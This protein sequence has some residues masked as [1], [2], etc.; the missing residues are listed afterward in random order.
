MTEAE[1]AACRNPDEMLAFLR[2]GGHLSS[3]KD[4]LFAVACC[5]RVWPLLTDERS[6]RAVEAAEG[7]A[8][9]LVTAAQL[10]EVRVAAHDAFFHAKDVEYRAEA[11]VNFCDSV[12]YSRVCVTLYA[13]AAARVAVSPQASRPID[14]LA[15]YQRNESRWR[16]RRDRARGCHY[17]LMAAAGRAE[18]ARQYQA[19]GMADDAH[20]PRDVVG[21]ASDAEDAVERLEA[22]AQAALLRDLFGPLPFRTA[23]LAASVLAWNNR[24]VVRLAAAIYEEGH[25]AD[26]PLLADALLDA[27]CEDDE[28]VAHLRAPGPHARGCHGLDLVLG[29]R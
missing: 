12:A 15:A 14:L 4:R 23:A 5:R 10:R 26:L 20:P 29:L 21:W 2:E 27:G 22:A 19:S 16:T 28:V 17:W 24:L 13:A 7:F 25:W 11:E 6:R 9:G 8:D 18:R 1:W 3:R